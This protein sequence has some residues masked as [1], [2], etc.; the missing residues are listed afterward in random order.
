MTPTHRAAV[1]LLRVVPML[2]IAVTLLLAVA[3]V[4]S[5]QDYPDGGKDRPPRVEGNQFTNDP[6]T[7]EPHGSSTPDGPGATSGTTGPATG[8]QGTLP[9]TGTDLGILVAAGAVLTTAGALL[10]RRGAPRTGR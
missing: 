1:H 4:T 2:A 10:R 8:E 9:M 7:A 6:D 3:P 5:A